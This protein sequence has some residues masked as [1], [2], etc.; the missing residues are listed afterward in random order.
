M[1]VTPRQMIYFAHPKREEDMC[2]YENKHISAL[3]PSSHNTMIRIVKEKEI[4]GLSLI[5]PSPKMLP[6]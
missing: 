1:L 2:C 6:V 4:P 5:T 3:G